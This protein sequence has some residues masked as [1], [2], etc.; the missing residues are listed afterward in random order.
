MAVPVAE[1]EDG[2]GV[3]DVPHGVS[4]QEVGGWTALMDGLEDAQTRLIKP[5]YDDFLAWPGIVGVVLLGFY[6]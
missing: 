3:S 5:A 2:R 6:Y 4:W 1:P